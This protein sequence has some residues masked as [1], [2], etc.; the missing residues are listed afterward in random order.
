MRY[1]NYREQE[2]KS[3][4]GSPYKSPVQK[5]VAGD[6]GES[7]YILSGF[8]VEVN[9]KRIVYALRSLPCQKKCCTKIPAG[10]FGSTI[11]NNHTVTKV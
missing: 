10:K 2:D 9:L 1:N 11:L 8:E 3:V 5:D 7:S 4:K 6:T